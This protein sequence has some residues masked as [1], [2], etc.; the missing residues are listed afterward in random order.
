MF[1]KCKDFKNSIFKD[2]MQQQGILLWTHNVHFSNDWNFN[3]LQEKHLRLGLF[4]CY[5]IAQYENL[6]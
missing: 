2:K 1:L 3:T 4:F 6:K 5:G